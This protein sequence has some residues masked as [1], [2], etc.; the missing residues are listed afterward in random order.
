MQHAQDKFSGAYYVLRVSLIK[1][2]PKRPTAKAHG[3][4][5]NQQETVSQNLFAAPSRMKPE[6]VLQHHCVAFFITK[7]HNWRS[8]LTWASLGQFVFVPEMESPQLQPRNGRTP[9][10]ISCGSVVLHNGRLPLFISCGSNYRL[11]QRTL[12]AVH[13]L[14]L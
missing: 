13:F 6:T 4:S 1:Y 7:P 3:A 8:R 5:D 2:T 14:W 9:L 11:T 10:F 12:I